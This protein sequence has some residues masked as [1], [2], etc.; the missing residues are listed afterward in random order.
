M[1]FYMLY[2]AVA[3][4]SRRDDMSTTKLLGIDE[5][6]PAKGILYSKPHIW[7]KIRE[8]SFPSP[9]RLGENRIAFVEAEIDAWIE[10]KVAER[11]SKRRS[12]DVWRLQIWRGLRQR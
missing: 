5:L 12:R 11:D 8:G 1:P 10:A 4:R 2:G 7:R 3:S 6:R 9:I